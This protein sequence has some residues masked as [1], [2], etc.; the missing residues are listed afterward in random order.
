MKI[1]ISN[2]NIVLIFV[3][4]LLFNVLSFSNDPATYYYRYFHLFVAIIAIFNRFPL[5]INN[6]K[7]N[8]VNFLLFILFYIVRIIIDH[9][10]YGQ[11]NS[12]D[13][14]VQ[15]L[16]ISIIPAMAIFTSKINEIF[17]LSNIVKTLI[18][19]GILIGIPRLGVYSGEYEGRIGI[20]ENINSLLLGQF[21][22]TLFILSY[23]SLVTKHRSILIYYLNIFYLF[24]SILIIG[25]ASSRSPI[26]SIILPI[27][28]FQLLYKGFRK[29]LNL[30]VI[31][32]FITIITFNLSQEFMLSFGSSFVDRIN[33]SIN[34]GD[35]SGR[36]F[37]YYDSFKQFLSSPFIGKAHFLLNQPKVGRYPHNLIFESFIALGLLGGLLFISMIISTIKKGYNIMKTENKT[38]MVSW[39][40][41]LFL[42]FLTFGM[43][44]GSLYSSYYFWGSLFLINHIYNELH[45]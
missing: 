37:I 6:L 13:H 19:F 43:F 2:F 4:Y 30:I 36:F 15:F 27:I 25:I 1:N 44:S 8:R 28:S 29:S 17:K 22:A 33:L 38:I 40:F 24:F 21:S 12:I 3:G 16:I 41:L 10:N 31:L 34:E 42:Q 5:F 14:L 32:S 26:I 9:F 23:Y 39:G 18:F 20:N 45:G 7:K 35:T 11:V